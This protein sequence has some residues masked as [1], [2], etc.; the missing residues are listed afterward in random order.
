MAVPQAHLLSDDDGAFDHNE[1][2]LLRAWLN[3]LVGPK[4]RCHLQSL[5]D[6][7]MLTV[8]RAISKACDSRPFMHFHVFQA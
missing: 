4:L 7:V 1:E 5:F 6:P 8:R 3:Q 2:R